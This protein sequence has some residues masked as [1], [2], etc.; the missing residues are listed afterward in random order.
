MLVQSIFFVARNLRFP[1]E[2]LNPI[3]KDIRKKGAIAAVACSHA[4]YTL[5]LIERQFFSS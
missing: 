1:V 5:I 4:C 2:T 3:I